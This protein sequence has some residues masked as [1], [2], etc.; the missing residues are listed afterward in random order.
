MNDVVEGGAGTL[1]VTARRA[2]EVKASITRSARIG[3]NVRTTVS[4]LQATLR[5][6]DPVLAE[7][8][9]VAPDVQP[10]LAR[11]RPTITQASALLADA[12]P[13]LR[14]L[15]PTAAALASSAKDGRPLLRDIEPALKRADE[16]ILPDLAK[17][18]QITGRPTYQMIG[19]T[20]SAL[21]AAAG[22]YDAVSHVVALTAGAGE[23]ALDTLPCR[24][25]FGDPAS[26]KLIACQQ[27]SQYLPT[28]FG[29][30]S[31]PPTTKKAR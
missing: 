9:T 3:P 2:A 31:P 27:L 23:R 6:A 12:R 25:Y 14:D 11:L 7:L 21:D 17:P 20:I 24:T 26:P 29:A 8:E 1:T 4:R 19:S 30:P 18:D 16:T 5:L 15:R 28:L 22:G 13:L 10:T